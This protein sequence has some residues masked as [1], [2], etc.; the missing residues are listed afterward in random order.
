[1]SRTKYPRTFHLPWSQGATEDDKTHTLAV[2]EQMFGGKQVVVT[3]KMDGENTT[4]YSTGECHA[5]STSDKPHPSRD[6]VR[7]KARE[8]GCLGFPEGW[9][10]HGENLYARHSIE[11]DLLPE[12]L[13][14]FGIVDNS[15]VAR[16]WS[17]VE[18]W[19]ALLDLPHAPVLWKGRWDTKK[20]MGLWPFKSLLSSGGTSEGY[21]VRD[22]GAFPMSAFDKHVAKF[23]RAG[24]VQ[25][26]QH[27]TKKPVVPNRR[28]ALAQRVASRWCNE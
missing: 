13:V 25:T 11:Y 26:D 28:Q 24:H 6:W 14:I 10:I 18:D 20:V 4:I 1:M 12:Y 27:W 22:A 16:P 19:A 9:R 2:I 5:R 23:V 7:G 8:I 3:E 15:N 17:E 21:V